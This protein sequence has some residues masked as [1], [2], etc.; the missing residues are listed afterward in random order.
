VFAATLAE[1]NMVWIIHR[2]PSTLENGFL[3]DTHEM[4]R[5]SWVAAVF[6]GVLLRMEIE[7]LRVSGVASDISELVLLEPTHGVANAVSY[8]FC[9]PF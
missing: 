4:R 3:S 1:L 5:L 9:I 6:I 7:E 8:F 2:E